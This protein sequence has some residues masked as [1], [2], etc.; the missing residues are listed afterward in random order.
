MP[1]VQSGGSACGYQ[2]SFAALGRTAV[3]V[4]NRPWPRRAVGLCIASF[5]VNLRFCRCAGGDHGDEHEVT[6]GLAPAGRMLAEARSILGAEGYMTDRRPGPG[7]GRVR[8]TGT[9]D[10]EGLLADA[11]GVRAA[12][13]EEGVPVAAFRVIA[14]AQLTILDINGHPYIRFATA[15]GGDPVAVEFPSGRVVEMVT[16]H[17]PPPDTI[18]SIASTTLPWVSSAG[19]GRRFMPVSRFTAAQSSN[20]WKP[21]ATLTGCV[22]TC[23]LI[24]T[25]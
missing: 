15:T 10:I 16:R 6:P 17:H 3:L 4:T 12:L 2:D 7:L 18:V 1:G 21:A 19:S 9:A 20:R 25:A 5:R 23:S 24:L 14:D 8:F 11:P 22:R 13:L